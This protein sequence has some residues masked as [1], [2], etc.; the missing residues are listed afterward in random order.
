MHG[1]NDED[2]VRTSS[3]VREH[4]FSLWCERAARRHAP[5][6]DNDNA[7]EAVNVLQPVT[8]KYDCGI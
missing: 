6:V 2:D 7:V 8:H 4:S 1:S 3:F 5:R